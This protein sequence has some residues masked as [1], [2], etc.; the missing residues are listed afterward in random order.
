MR[1]CIFSPSIASLVLNTNVCYIFTTLKPAIIKPKPTILIS[2]P[3]PTHNK[4][5]PNPFD[6]P[7]PQLKQTPRI[8]YKPGQT[9]LYPQSTINKQ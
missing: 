1:F 2:Q 5:K 8:L 7:D 3:N 6:V 4:L 9:T